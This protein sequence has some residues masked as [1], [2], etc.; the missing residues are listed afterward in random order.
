MGVCVY[1]HRMWDESLWTLP[2]STSFSSTFQIKDKFW[3]QSN[4]G[5][6]MTQFWKLNALLN[7]LFSNINKS[8]EVTRIS[9]IVACC[10]SWFFNWSRQGQ[11]LA[12]DKTL[13]CTDSGVMFSSVHGCRGLAVMV[14][15]KCCF[16]VMV[17]H[18]RFLFP[19]LLGQV[20]LPSFIQRGPCEPSSGRFLLYTWPFG[21]TVPFAFFPFSRLASAPQSVMELPSSF[22][23]TCCD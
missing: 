1:V 19:W 18:Y 21:K 14:N 23:L 17:F 8:S 13:S 3:K 2:F 10:F 9:Y 12:R 20:F 22:P 15:F 6:K 16:L 4:E 11:G 5:N 7:I